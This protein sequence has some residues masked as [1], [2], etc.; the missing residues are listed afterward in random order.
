MANYLVREL[1]NQFA[2]ICNCGYDVVE[3]T[4]DESHLYFEVPDEFG[5]IGFE[6]VSAID[7]TNPPKSVR[8]PLDA[9]CGDFLVKYSELPVIA[10]AFENALSVYQQAA[11][12]NSLSR[13]Q[14]DSAHSA[15]VNLRNLKARLDIAMSRA[16]FKR[17]Q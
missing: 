14:R 5:T 2:E 4:N 9:V 1:L 11:D 8:F 17:V 10:Q 12:D 6:G 7:E 16:G 15:A 3:I 13:A